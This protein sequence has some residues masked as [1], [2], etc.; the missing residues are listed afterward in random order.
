MRTLKDN[1]KVKTAG[2]VEAVVKNIV[3]SCHSS[4][5]AAFNLE[6]VRTYLEQHRF[7]TY[8]QIAADL[9]M[10]V[11]TAGDHVRTIKRETFRTRKEL[12]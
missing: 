10:C 12:I 5:L 2:I 3:K 11:R 7:C 1:I 9:D 4:D 8:K 6:K